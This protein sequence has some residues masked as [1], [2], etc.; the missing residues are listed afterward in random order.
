MANET[1]ISRYLPIAG[2]LPNCTSASVR[3][4]VVAG[5]AVAGL[6]V[7]EGMAYAGIAGVAPQI[8][9]YAAMAGMFV[10]ALFGTSR[11]L[12]VTATSSS[13]AMTA[14]LVA[15]LAGGDSLHY[16]ALVA[17]AAIAAGLIFLGCG[18]F[19]VGSV[20]E[21]ISK[22]VLKGFVFGL[23]L[24][25]IV[26]QMAHFTGIPRGQGDFFGQLWHVLKSI[27]E[28]NPTTLILGVVSLS[29]LA[30]LGTFAPRVPSALVVLVLGILAVRLLGLESRGVEVVGDV[31]GSMPSFAIPRI[32]T[33]DLPEVFVGTLGIVVVLAAE[34][35]AAGRT[36]AAKHKYET[37][38]NQ[39]LVAMGAANVVS[40][41]LG[42]LI[43]GGGMSGT[44]A[45]DAGG[46]RTQLS[47]ITGSVFVALTLAFLMPSIRQL[48]EAVLAAIVIHAVA[49]LV[50][51]KLLKYYARIQTGSVWI[52][53]IAIAGVLLLGI[54]KGLILAVA[55]T[56]VIIYEEVERAA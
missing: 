19:K 56:L 54:L 31:Q 7:P 44:A 45:N 13:A 25:I 21:F 10:Y 4:D 15:P 26:K 55:V 52:A 14:A 38:A 50:D 24:T 34:G 30:L 18:L 48:P 8:G 41:L 49:H 33:D 3:A 40:G 6:L 20:V 42:G 29:I 17:A 11:Q 35:L 51:F 32:G 22:P 12:A 5:I 37:D 16:A 27:H 1:G 53:S 39:E 28:V 9:L 2:W 36:F 43:V 47:T 46:A 23:G